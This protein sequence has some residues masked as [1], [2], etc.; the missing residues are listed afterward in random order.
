MYTDVKKKLIQ[1]RNLSTVIITSVSNT[2]NFPFQ[3]NG[4]ILKIIDLFRV[5][6]KCKLPLCV[7]IIVA[8][9]E[10]DMELTSKPNKIHTIFFLANDWN[11]NFRYL[12]PI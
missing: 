5:I 4:L 2:F 10:F 6:S 1:S 9:S 8:I 7:T 11:V 3:I 12:F